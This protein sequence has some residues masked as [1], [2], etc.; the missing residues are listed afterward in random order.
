MPDFPLYDRVRLCMCVCFRMEPCVGAHLYMCVN[1]RV[2]AG[3]RH[4]D[5]KTTLNILFSLVG[6]QTEI[7]NERPIFSTPV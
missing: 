1:E 2:G 6:C 4:T 3:K 5:S 7:N